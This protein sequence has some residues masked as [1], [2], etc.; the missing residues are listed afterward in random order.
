[1]SG[2]EIP[3]AFTDQQLEIILSVASRLPRR[4]RDTFLL[5]VA[6]AVAGRPFDAAEFHRAA[7]A[8]AR[9][10][11]ADDARARSFD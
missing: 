4:M 3:L 8:V 7:L 10:V 2:G 9:R 1:M 11:V 5:A 6:D